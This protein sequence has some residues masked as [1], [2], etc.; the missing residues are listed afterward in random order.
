MPLR[1]FAKVAPDQREWLEFF[2]RRYDQTYGDLVTSVGYKG[3]PMLL[4]MWLCLICTKANLMKDVAWIGA[5][6]AA[7]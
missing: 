7:T 4:S 5:P 2:G 3:D 1:A 6:I